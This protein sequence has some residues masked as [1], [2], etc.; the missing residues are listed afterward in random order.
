MLDAGLREVEV[1]AGERRHGSKVRSGGGAPDGDAVWIDAVFCGIGPQEADGGFDVVQRR[2]KASF[3]AQPVLHRRDHE[4]A[5]GERGEHGGEV[6]EVAGGAFGAGRPASAVQEDDERSRVIASGAIEVEQHRA[7]AGHGRI[8]DIRRHRDLAQP[9]ARGRKRVACDGACRNLD[10][11]FVSAG[12]RGAVCRKAEQ[13][14][15]GERFDGTAVHRNSEF[16]VVQIAL[17]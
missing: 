4:A 13:E 9:N 15:E 8:G 6:G 1:V 17:A 7:V 2:R 10:G 5:F 14:G 16:T 12:Q 3:A 11:R